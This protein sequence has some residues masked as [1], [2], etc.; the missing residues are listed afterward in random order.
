MTSP[1]RGLGLIFLLAGAL[2]FTQMIFA[3]LHIQGWLPSI[4]VSAKA[5]S[6]LY[7]GHFLFLV[8]AG[9]SY[10]TL[11]CARTGL[12]SAQG[13]VDFLAGLLFFLIFY[14]ILIAVLVRFRLTAWLSL[15]PGMVL[16]YYGFRLKRGKQWPQLEIAAPAER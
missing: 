13:L 11:D 15:W 1:R 5:W 6:W 10:L 12:F 16:F 9:M 4:Y 14:F 2:Y 8:L 3:V 7:Y